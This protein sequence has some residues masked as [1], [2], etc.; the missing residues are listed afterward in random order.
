MYSH[1]EGVDLFSVKGLEGAYFYNTF[2]DDTRL[3][4]DQLGEEI[5]SGLPCTLTTA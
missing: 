2:L 5:A 3:K 1:L 4:R